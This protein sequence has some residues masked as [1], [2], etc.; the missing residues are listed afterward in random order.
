[1]FKQQNLSHYKSLFV[2]FHNPE[3]LEEAF[4]KFDAREYIKTIKSV[5]PDMVMFWANDHYGNC[6]YDTKI[7]H[8]HCRLKADYFGELAVEAHKNQMAVFAYFV[9]G[10]HNYSAIQHPDWEQVGPDGK[11]WNPFPSFYWKWVCLNSPQREYCVAQMKEITRKYAIEGIWIDILMTLPCG[12]YCQ[13]CQEKFEKMYGTPIPR[14]PERG[15]IEAKRITDFRY[16]NTYD[17][18]LEAKAQLE[19]IKPEL[20]ITYNGSGDI[21]FSAIDSDAL[22]DKL[23]Q[24]RALWKSRWTKTQGKPFEF[25]ITRGY[26]SWSDWV[27]K[28]LDRLRTEVSTILANGGRVLLGDHGNPDGTLEPYVYKELAVIFEEI[29]KAKEWVRDTR[30]VSDVAI[31]HS[32]ESHKMKQWLS[33]DPT[34]FLADGLLSEMQ[35]AYKILIEGKKQFEIIS[36][37]NL[38]HLRQ[39]N[40]LIIPNQLCLSEED[41]QHI[42]EFVRNGGNLISTYETGLRREDGTLRENFILNKIMGVD[43]L[44]QSLFSIDYIDDIEDCIKDNLPEIPLLISPEPAAVRGQTKGVMKAS[45]LTRIDTAQLLARITHP[46]CERTPEHWVSH[47]HSNPRDKTQYPAIAYH[48]YGQGQSVYFAQPIFKA[49]WN[50]EYHPL[51]DLVLNILRFLNQRDTIEVTAPLGVEVVLTRREKNFIIHLVNLPQWEL[52]KEIKQLQESLP[53]FNIEVKLKA[54]EAKKVLLPLLENKSLSFQKGNGFVSFKVPQLE[55]H[56]IVVVEC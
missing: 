50:T 38:S 28:P 9:V 7:G 43:F 15:S 8:K 56:Q 10:W 26:Y 12:C 53:I 41:V 11:P 30:S 13:S 5:K 45:V 46:S 18:F 33:V 52:G 19:K 55:V 17:F 24:E 2:D 47:S 4:Q 44:S 27:I 22:S 54:P 25:L 21:L 29:D 35:G 3:F 51:R 37:K 40:N 16:K 42:E 31:L 49:Y 23:S 32:V 14:N 39:Y 36:E 20:I 34:Q 6:F 48:K 1:M